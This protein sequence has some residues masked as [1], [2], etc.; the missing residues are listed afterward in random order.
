MR[1]VINANIVA[2][3]LVR[4]TGWTAG[5]LARRDVEFVAPQFLKTEL[6]EH[7]TE[8]AQKAE[9]AIVE[10]RRRTDAVLANIRMVPGQ[11]L[12]KYVRHSL[13]QAMDAI[14]PEDVPYVATFI[15]TG[16]DFVW[17]RDGAL[18]AMMGERAGPV[19]P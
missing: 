15:E 12:R 2:A 11:R 10:W 16:A 3:A 17:T 5:Q 18:K 13:V 4:P 8:Y 14:D 9:C 1:V 19:I 7:E 6:K